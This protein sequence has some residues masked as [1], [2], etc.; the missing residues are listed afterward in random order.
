M[1]KIEIQKMQDIFDKI[2]ELK[3]KKLLKEL[4]KLKLGKKTN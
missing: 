2:S 1:N 3:R 4:L